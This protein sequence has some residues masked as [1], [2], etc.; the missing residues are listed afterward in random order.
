MDNLNFSEIKDD[1]N[2]SFIY[3]DNVKIGEI[4]CT[5]QFENGESFLLLSDFCI[6]KSYRNKGYGTKTLQY[7]IQKYKSKYYQIY[8]WVYNKNHNAINLY[9]K[10]A[11]YITKSED[12]KFYYVVFYQKD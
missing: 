8:C 7:V 12:E 1:G 3:K 11:D 10:I 2:L 9:L 5:P 6:Y 4:K